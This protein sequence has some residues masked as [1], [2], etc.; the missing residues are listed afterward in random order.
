MRT[1]FTV[2][3]AMLGLVLLSVS[4][5]RAA[6]MPTADDLQSQM[7]TPAETVTVYELHLSVGDDLVAA[8]YVGYPAVDVLARLFGTDWHTQGDTV[9][10]RAL[11][12]Y[13][14]R[15][16]ADRLLTIDAYLV[17]AHADG[18]PFTVDNLLQNQTDVPLGPYYL[19]WDNIGNPALIQEGPGTWIYQV[20]DANLV[21]LSDEALLPAGLDARFHEGAALAMTHCLNC[22][23]V[24]GYGGEKFEGN[25][26]EF[27]KVY[28]EADFISLVLAPLS[29]L[30]E[31]TMPPLS[32]RLDE[33]DRQRIAEALFDY[34]V[35]LPVLE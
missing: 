28:D 8:D 24:N 35:A 33:D 11:D 18:S 10:F 34:L 30:E 31:T 3:C 2:L 23:M 29:V 9:E 16:A 1:R 12:G 6:E 20:I 25:L 7:G 22:H 17:F 26:A 15:V 5:G 19:V 32:P 14:L 13:V 21:S 4:A 27:A